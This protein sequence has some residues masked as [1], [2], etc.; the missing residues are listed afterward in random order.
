MYFDL[1]PDGLVRCY[2]AWKLLCIDIHYTYHRLS[3][4]E[5]NTPFENLSEW[6]W[7]VL[8]SQYMPKSLIFF[9]Y[10]VIRIIKTLK[11][12]SLNSFGLLDAQ[13]LSRRYIHVQGYYGAGKAYHLRRKA[14]DFSVKEIGRLIHYIHDNIFIF[15]VGPF[16]CCLNVGN[17]FGKR[18]GR[19]CKLQEIGVTWYWMRSELPVSWRKIFVMCLPHTF[20]MLLTGRD[21]DG[22]RSWVIERGVFDCNAIHVR[23]RMKMLLWNNLNIIKKRIHN[24]LTLE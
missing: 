6:W 11:E 14:W 10:E 4:W 19:L 17:K 23:C 13:V 9:I 20:R 1:S 15:A 7:N 16:A 12:V 21:Y 24:I 18:Y 5:S 8:L 3:T 22:V 2:S